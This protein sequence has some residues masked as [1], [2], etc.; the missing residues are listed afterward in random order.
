MILPVASYPFPQVG[1]RVF[2]ASSVNNKGGRKF[3]VYGE[4][5]VV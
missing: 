5:E 1:F 4:G 2:P 3:Y